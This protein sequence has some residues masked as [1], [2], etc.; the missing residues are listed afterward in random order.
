MFVV[1]LVNVVRYGFGVGYVL[2]VVVVDEG[3]I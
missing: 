2:L 3:V 1:V